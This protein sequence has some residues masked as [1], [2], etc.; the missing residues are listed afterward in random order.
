MLPKMHLFLKQKNSKRTIVLIHAIAFVFAS[1]FSYGNVPQPIQ[2]EWQNQ[3]VWQV[4]KEN[5][6]AHFIP[7]ASKL[8]ISDDIF[9]SE[10]IQS[11]N[12]IWKFKLVTKPADRPLDFY[13]NSFNTANWDNINVPA[14]WELEGYD[15]PIYT[16]V[17]YPHAK[18]PPVIQEHYNP[19]GS[20][21]R[22]F[23]LPKNWK[24]KDVIL[25][26]GAVSS[27][28]YVWVN[29]QK[30]GYS[31]DTKVPAEFNITPFLKEGENTISAQ[32]FRWCDGSY[33][34][35]Q[36]FWRMSGITRDVYLLV[37][38]KQHIIDFRVKSPLV[39]N[40]TDG[41]LTVNV[42]LA[43]GLKKNSLVKVKWILEKQGNQISSSVI[44]KKLNAGTDSVSFTHLVKEALPWTAETPA[45]Y[46]LFIELQ[47]SKGEVIEVI[48]QDVGF[49]TIE[50]KDGTLQVNGRY[51]YLKGVN[52]HEHN[53]VT[54]HVQD[55]ATMLK[56]IL[57]MKTHNI[58]AVRTA[59]YPEPERFYELCNRYGIYLIDEANIESHGMGYSKESL[60]KDETW[61]GAHLYRTQNMYERDKNQP[62]IIIWSLGNEAGNG[63]NFYA[64]YDYL[65]SVDSS[66]PVQYEQAGQDR[67]TDIVCPMYARFDYLNKYANSNPTRPMI[68]CEY[69]HAMGNSVG[70]L[71]DYWN[72]Y[73]AFKSLQGGFIWDWVD[74]GILTKSKEGESFWAYGGDFGPEDVPSDGNFCLNGIINPDRTVKPTLLEVKKVYQNI[75]FEAVNAV[76]GSI[77][78]ANKFSFVDLNNYNLKWEV[79]ENG[80]AIK[81]GT[82]NFPSVKPGEKK[83]IDLETAFSPNEKAE[84]YLNV[85]AVTKTEEN[86]IPENYTIAYEQF[87][88]SHSATDY[89]YTADGADLLVKE[90]GETIE[91]SGSS[92]KAMFSKNNGQLSQ[93][94][95]NSKDMLLKG[96]IPDFWRAPTDNDFGNDFPVRSRMWRKAGERVNDVKTVFQKTDSTV[97]IV[98]TMQLMDQNSQV[99]ANY[100]TVYN[101]YKNGVIKVD[102]EFTKA[103]KD[104]PEIMRMGMN[105]QL[106]REFENMTW[107]GRGPHESYWD[108]K[109]SALVGQYSGLV[110]DQFWAY[111]RPQE[112]GN[113][114]D[115]RWVSL[116]NSRGQGLLFEGLPLI[117][118]NASHVLM[119]D[120]ES[121]KR[122]DGR[123]SEGEK[124][125]RRHVNDVKFRDLTSVNIDYKQM[126]VG[127]DDSWGA[128]THEEY[129]LWGNSYKYSFVIKPLAGN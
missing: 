36:D 12:G 113:K 34:E 14:N 6:R 104:L 65:K 42:K 41:L 48:R 122:T 121:P 127:G 85:Y 28:M 84:Y 60:A 51:I 129:R 109:T 124:P 108:R 101:I 111:L 22:T 40:Y 33:L 50:I 21:K 91:V 56:D 27:A 73:E 120:I 123:H 8:A 80:K 59:H 93:Y 70:N 106:L 54:G 24:A 57:L 125:V 105:L 4:N 118:V 82:L 126:G 30:V 61:K 5:P 66:R 94:Q 53:Q 102:N 19:V 117:D 83:Q 13:K 1:H 90:L 115:V 78:V 77:R 128:W 92:F 68:Q 119:E 107:Y 38:D 74:Q 2:P 9:A 95:F 81:Q 25:H 52:I 88:I 7:F 26:F 87:L 44:E 99:I 96:L 110:K 86:L 45:L 103:S 114:T 29:E 89:K 46:D 35:D 39:N 18:T 11:L 72:I 43:N 31:E 76:K 79:L 62:S 15:Y 112:N 75:G 10:F 23:T 67:N 97:Q 71:Q 55:E 58:N 63:V 32:V 64:T 3:F 47:N 16:N 37:R 49:R 17:Q 116:T 20:Y 100:K 98:S 69:A